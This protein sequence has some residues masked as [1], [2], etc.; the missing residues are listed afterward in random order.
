MAT[1]FFLHTLLVIT[2]LFRAQCDETIQ[3][4]PN[5]VYTISNMTVNQE[6]NLTFNNTEYFNKK[7]NSIHF[8]FSKSFEEKVNISVFDETKSLL[9]NY[10]DVDTFVIIF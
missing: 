9:V 1:K 5:S 8:R 7:V 4:L 2:F 10:T 6:I 3:L